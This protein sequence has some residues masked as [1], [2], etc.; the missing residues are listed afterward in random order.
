[1]TFPAFLC[2]IS[3]KQIQSPGARLS[4]PTKHSGW[5]VS[6]LSWYS[7]GTFP[8]IQAQLRSR[9]PRSERKMSVLY[10]NRLEE[11]RGPGQSIPAVITPQLCFIWK[12]KSV[13]TY[14]LRHIF[15]YTEKSWA[16]NKGKDERWHCRC[17][18]HYANFSIFPCMLNFNFCL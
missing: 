12:H 8:E 4:S 7:P 9:S 10:I 17:W 16:N 11:A 2:S 3:E 13:H 1:M 14:L 5:P 18:Q 15:M 6:K